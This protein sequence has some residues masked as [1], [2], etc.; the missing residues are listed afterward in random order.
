MKEI[1]AKEARQRSKEHKN[2]TY[3]DV[4]VNNTCCS[5]RSAAVNG[6]RHLYVKHFECADEKARRL[7]DLGF[8][9]SVANGGFHIDW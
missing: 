3:I 9:V 8:E 4:W 2:D 5:I 6:E 7:R 1:T